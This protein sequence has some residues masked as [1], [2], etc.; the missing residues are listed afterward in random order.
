MGKRHTIAILSP[1]LKPRASALFILDSKEAGIADVCHREPL[2]RCRHLT[3]AP[4]RHLSARYILLVEF[5]E[6]EMTLSAFRERRQS[7]DLA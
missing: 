3:F 5:K 4:L 2:P 7:L 6:M 1:Y